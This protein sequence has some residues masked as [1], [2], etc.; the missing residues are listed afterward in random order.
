MNTPEY[1]AELRTAAEK[2]L[3]NPDALWW[4]VVILSSNNVFTWLQDLSRLPNGSVAMDHM[5]NDEAAFAFLL[6]AEALEAGDLP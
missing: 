4:Y 2:L 6:L 3:S 1:A 5:T